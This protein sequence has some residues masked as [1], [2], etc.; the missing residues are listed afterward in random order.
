MRSFTRWFSAE[1]GVSPH[2]YVMQARIERAKSL[3]ANTT[4]PLSEVALDC[5]FSSQSHLST[6]FRRFTGR[7]PGRFR[8]A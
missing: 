7:T 3:L 8:K 4:R 5:G 1:F 6:V 2:R